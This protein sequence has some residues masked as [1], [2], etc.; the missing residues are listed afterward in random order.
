VSEHPE[1]VDVDALVA[2][3]WHARSGSYAPYSNFN[4]GA[5][6]LAD[7]RVFRGAN[8]ENASY[9]VAICAERVAASHAVSSG[10]RALQAVAVTSSARGPASPCGVCR[11]FLYEFNPHML[12]ISEGLEGE[13]KTWRL[14]DLLSDGFGPGD[15][16][17]AGSA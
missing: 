17:S 3:A 8:V 6:V 7:G 13:R 4:V 9:S 5:A 1:T 15:L 12:V 11:Q 2:E 16:A 10:A 14:A